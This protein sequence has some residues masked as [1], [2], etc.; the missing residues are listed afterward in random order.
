MA[1]WEKKKAIQTNLTSDDILNDFID[2]PRNIQHKQDSFISTG[3]IIADKVLGGGWPCGSLIELFAEEGGGKTALLI[4]TAL[5]VQQS[6]YGVA[7]FDTEGGFNESYVKSRGGLLGREN[8]EAPILVGRYKSTEE[9]DEKLAKIVKHPQ[10]KF[11]VIDSYQGMVPSKILEFGVADVEPGLQA[12]MNS[13]LLTKCVKYAQ[14]YQKVI[15]IVNQMRVKIDFKTGA[16][17]EAGGG[18]TIKFMASERVFLKR[19][20][21]VEE[22]IE[23][24]PFFEEE[25]ARIGQWVDITTYKNR[26]TTPFRTGRMFLRYGVGYDNIQT[27]LELCKEEKIIVQSSSYF[28]MKLPAGEQTVQGTVAAREFVAANVEFFIQALKEKG[29]T[30]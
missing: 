21:F 3:N 7:Y 15:V 22:T 14:E 16:T 13:V 9:I 26:L 11:I 23:G 4:D 8:P 1:R 24:N 28:K 20:A 19:T 29:I 5:L 10:I 25:K 17:Y 2:D 27:I 18:S 12:R 30:I 6:G